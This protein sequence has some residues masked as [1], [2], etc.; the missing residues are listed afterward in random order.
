[1]AIGTYLY[2]LT[3]GYQYYPVFCN[4]CFVILGFHCCFCYFF[5]ALFV[6]FYYN[7]Y[8][9]GFFACG[10]IMSKQKK[11][12]KD[13]TIKDNFMF[14]AVMVDEENCRRCLELALGI[15]IEK[16]TVCQEKSI[17]Y[18]PEHKGV[19]LDVIA[20]DEKRTRY[21]I[22][23]QVSAKPALGRRTRY[24][25]S[26]LD[27]EM[28]E[29]GSD[30]RELADVYVIFICD[31]DP[32]GKQLYRYTWDMIC[33]EVPEAELSDGSHTIIL[34]TCGENDGEVPGELVTF[35]KFVG[36]G[37]EESTKDYADD[38][39]RRLQASVAHV[40]TN[41]EMEAKYMLW[42]EF[43]NEE[44]E[45]AREEGHAEGRAEGLA[46]GLAEGNINGRIEM[47]FEQLNDMP[48]HIS[49]D[50]EAYI[51]GTAD[52]E[53]LKT[54]ARK[55]RTATSVQEFEEMIKDIQ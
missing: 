50:L 48:G 41:R 30:Y 55:V 40:K 8:A 9:E 17:V 45:E 51:R 28:L 6:F 47:L 26:Q 5:V 22:E 27:M 39:I 1:L 46:E 19:R 31:Y 24:Y 38:Y 15:P 21:N 23:M 12:L 16:V 18:H 13:L 35:L 36:A 29:T 44:R 33:R 20:K 43:I 53:T 25:H 37:L 11:K 34:S 2:I 14:G 7:T 52:T 49:A 54:Y 10:G 32:F 42:K 4:E 3:I